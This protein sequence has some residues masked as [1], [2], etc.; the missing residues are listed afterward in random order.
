MK[1]KKGESGMNKQILIGIMATMLLLPGVVVAQEPPADYGELAAL[2]V[3]AWQIP[4][5][6]DAGDS[7]PNIA[8][9][10]E[11]GIGPAG[12]APQ[13]GV[14]THDSPPGLPLRF[15]PDQ[16][17]TNFFLCQLHT[18]TW[19]AAEVGMIDYFGP[20]SGTTAVL[21]LIS[22]HQRLTSCAAGGE[23]VLP[24]SP[25]QPEDECPECAPDPEN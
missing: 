12:L 23:E 5:A 20:E 15:F 11:I 2:M 13:M 10:N 24:L 4:A 18:L 17:L 1:V 14:S 8:A 21:D 7:D 9:L 3:E 6:S 25:G 22:L 19:A 16:E